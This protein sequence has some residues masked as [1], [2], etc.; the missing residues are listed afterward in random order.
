MALFDGLIEEVASKYGL[1]AQAGPLVREAV[2]VMTGGPG[3]FAG[4]LDRL[5]SA[6]LGSEV[7]SWIGSTAAPALS[8][9]TVQTAVGSS[10]IDGIAGRLG[11]RAGAVGAALGLVLPRVVGLLTRGGVVPQSLPAEALAFLGPAG[12]A[13]PAAG[14]VRP[15]MMT[16]IPEHQT[17][18]F[19]WGIPIAAALGLAALLWYLA[20]SAPPTPAI[21]P[22]PV[23][24]V[25]PPAPPV[26]A[27][28]Q[29]WLWLADDNGTVSYSG[30]VHDAGAKTTIVTALQNAFG[31]DKVKGAITVD[32][33]MAD[34]SWV[35]NLRTALDHLKVNGLQ[36]LF[37]GNSISV[38]G[39]ASD[40]DRDKLIG[41]LRSALG[42]SLAFGALSDKIGDLVSN[43][44][45]SAFAA[46]TTLKANFSAADLVGALNLAI[47]NFPTGSA[48]I[49]SAN[50]DLLRQA[51][52]KIKALPAGTVIEIGGHTDNTG[53][54]AANVA[55]SQQRADAVRNA[56]IQ[57]GVDASMLVAKGY[58]AT[59]PVSDN[60]SA[61]GRFRNRR[62]EYS[63][64]KTG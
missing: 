53:D 43:S 41:T 52:E 63:V 45:G 17:H 15:T 12:R 54:P 48:D 22:A 49:P 40:A 24:A 25:T 19:R 37:S 33:N 59:A 23:V 31:A 47:I 28:S 46:L 21:P 39:L 6:G 35:G 20:P 10:M 14:Q 44:T 36:T 26:T 50:S 55:L 32:P 64:V 1:G 11:L 7:T 8:A 58:G 60:G 2:G 16:V 62:I 5:R 4:C 29:P 56:L 13:A 51:A 3:G 34:A 30:Q 57:D 9:Q 61:I 27:A 42:G 18:F 38:G